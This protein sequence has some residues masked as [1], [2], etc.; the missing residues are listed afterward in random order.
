MAHN[1]N[2]EKKTLYFREGDWAFLESIMRPNGLATSV[3]IRS[4]VSK[5]VDERK[6]QQTPINLNLEADL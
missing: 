5:Y 4:I 6:G 3:A 1:D 2:L